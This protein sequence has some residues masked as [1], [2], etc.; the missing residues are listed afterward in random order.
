MGER[1]TIRVKHP[2]NPTPIHFYTHWRGHEIESVL[3]EGVQRAINFGRL[4][5][6]SYATRIIFDTLTQCTNDGLSF[7]I[8]IGDNNRPGD[9]TYDSPCIEWQG[10]C[11]PIFYKMTV[12]GGFTNQEHLDV[13][14]NRH[15]V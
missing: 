11:N 10:Y 15:T 4:T 5:D 9:V 14:L 3:A 6:I 8:E 1:A 13:F 2:D 12:D 7:G